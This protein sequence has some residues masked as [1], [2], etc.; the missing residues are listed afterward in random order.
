MNSTDD[1]DCDNNTTTKI[2]SLTTRQLPIDTP[3]A[4]FNCVWNPICLLGLSMN[5]AHNLSNRGQNIYFDL[6]NN[7]YKRKGYYETQVPHLVK[8]V[9]VSSCPQAAATSTTTN[10]YNNNNDTTT[11]STVKNEEWAFRV[12]SNKKKA[13]IAETAM[14]EISPSHGISS[15]LYLCTLSLQL[16]NPLW[17]IEYATTEFRTESDAKE[18]WNLEHILK[19]IPDG[20]SKACQAELILTITRR[21]GPLPPPPPPPSSP[22]QWCKTLLNEI[23]TAE[24]RSRFNL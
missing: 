2:V 16:S 15:G 1:N 13:D 10:N 4:Y 9:V 11:T 5:N 20:Q 21:M 19:H 18:R 8:V 24:F 17:K 6:V 7:G 22:S 3:H 23:T 14:V 12:T